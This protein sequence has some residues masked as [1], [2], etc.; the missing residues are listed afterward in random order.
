[1]DC[2]V[3]GLWWQVEWPSN[4]LVEYSVPPLS[5]LVTP[6]FLSPE[7]ARVHGMKSAYAKLQ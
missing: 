4:W 2:K 3:A 5:R 1:M 6:V 7:S